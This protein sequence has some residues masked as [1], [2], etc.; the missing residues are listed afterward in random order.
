MNW[1]IHQRV[2]E[3]SSFRPM[4]DEDLAR[5]CQ[6]LADVFAKS[7][8]AQ[9][10]LNKRALRLHPAALESLRSYLDKGV[11]ELRD[12]IGDR[13]R[14]EQRHGPAKPPPKPRRKKA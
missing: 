2:V 4:Q 12:R 9:M 1:R 5:A 8:Y 10:S 11:A 14:Q 13:V 3:V 7:V 6:L